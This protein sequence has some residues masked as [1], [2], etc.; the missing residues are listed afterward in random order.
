MRKRFFLFF[1]TSLGFQAVLVFL[2]W[3]LHISTMW[4]QCVDVLWYPLPSFLCSCLGVQTQRGQ[5]THGMAR[6][7]PTRLHM[8]QPTQLE[9]D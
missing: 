5:R 1:D 7:I 9:H 4:W 3:C 2:L 6:C 8:C